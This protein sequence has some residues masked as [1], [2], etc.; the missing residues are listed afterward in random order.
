MIKNIKK[1]FLKTK[2]AKVHSFFDY[3]AGEKTKIIRRA[4]KESNKMQ[5]DLVEEYDR[6]FSPA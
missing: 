3:S 2:L 5:K 1:V 6:Q 4:V